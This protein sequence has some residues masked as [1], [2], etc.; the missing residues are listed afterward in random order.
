MSAIKYPP[1]ETVWVQ[2]LNKEGDTISIIT[3]KESR[4]WYYLYDVIGGRLEKRGKAKEPPELIE[5]YAVYER[6]RQ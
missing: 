6:M 2:Y 3:S 4:D 5:K 1:G